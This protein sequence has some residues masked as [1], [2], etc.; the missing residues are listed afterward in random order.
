MKYKRKNGSLFNSPAATASS[1]VHNC[2]DKALQYLNLIVT[3]FDGAVPT[4]Y[5][6]N[7]YCQL[8]L[9]DTLEKVGISRY[10]S[11]E[12]TSVLDK[13]YSFWLRRD[14]EIMLDVTTCAMAFRL[15][16]MNGYDVSSGLFK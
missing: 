2:D 15:L 9:V 14:E 3:K 4:V 8:S 11:R 7:I 5:P 6:L 10:F 13:T 1:L 16:R 12:I